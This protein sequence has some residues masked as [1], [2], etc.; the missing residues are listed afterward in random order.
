MR[1]PLNASSTHMPPSSSLLC[2]RSASVL[3]LCDTLMATLCHL[4]SPVLLRRHSARRRTQKLEATRLETQGGP[5]LTCLLTDCFEGRG[6]ESPHRASHCF[7][8]FAEDENL[9]LLPA[10]ATSHDGFTMFTSRVN[11]HALCLLCFSD[12]EKITAFAVLYTS[13]SSHACHAS[14]DRYTVLGLF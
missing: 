3:R 11:I 9:G 14:C 10:A 7:Y 6:G 2:P 5:L 1:P 8:G 13:E 4:T 12:I